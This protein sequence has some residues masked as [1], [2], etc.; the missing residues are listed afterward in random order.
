MISEEKNRAQLVKY[1]TSLKEP[2]QSELWDCI[3]TAQRYSKQAGI[4]L[5]ISKI[6]DLIL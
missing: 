4:K 6:K 2:L 5:S 3:R 1:M